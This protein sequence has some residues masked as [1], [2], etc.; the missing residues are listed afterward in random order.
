MEKKKLEQKVIT[1]AERFSDLIIRQID[2][3][4]FISKNPAFEIPLDDA[5]K[6]IGENVRVLHH[7]TTMV[8]KF[9]ISDTTELTEFE[10][11][12]KSADGSDG[13][14]G[15]GIVQEIEESGQ[16]IQY[17]IESDLEKHQL[18]ITFPKRSKPLV[19]NAAQAEQFINHLMDCTS[20]WK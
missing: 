10:I 16:W 8:G 2:A 12:S 15:I 9:E 5:M 20:K 18:T 6:D 17:C 19:L 1:I 13:F 3:A 7:L 11:S 14:H 4:E